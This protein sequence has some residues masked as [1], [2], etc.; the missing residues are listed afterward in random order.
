MQAPKLEKVIVSSGIGSQKD[1]KKIE[2]IADRL[3]KITGQK[4]APRGCQAVNFKL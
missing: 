4:P 2:L 1:K 3:A